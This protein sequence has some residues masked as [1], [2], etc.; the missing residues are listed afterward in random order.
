MLALLLHLLA[1]EGK[2]NETEQHTLCTHRVC[3]GCRDF[4]PDKIYGKVQLD[5]LQTTR[6]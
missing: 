6:L 2:S 5:F 4:I 3:G 1:G